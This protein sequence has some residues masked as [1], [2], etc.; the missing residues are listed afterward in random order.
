MAEASEDEAIGSK[1]VGNALVKFGCFI[2]L[3]LE[4]TR[5]LYGYALVQG[6][7]KFNDSRS[8]E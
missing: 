1:H 5:S 3:S 8:E 6:G 2:L 7:R 4:C